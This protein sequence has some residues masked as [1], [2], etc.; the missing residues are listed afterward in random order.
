MSAMLTGPFIHSMTLAYRHFFNLKFL[1][2]NINFLPHVD[3]K[4]D[5]GLPL[6]L[7]PV[8]IIS[9]RDSISYLFPAYSHPFRIRVWPVV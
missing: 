3:D 4:Q 6:W 7:P 1:K 8:L 5:N 2:H 9:L